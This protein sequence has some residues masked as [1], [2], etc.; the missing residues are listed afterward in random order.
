MRVGSL[1]TRTVV[2]RFVMRTA[3][4]VGLFLVWEGISAL[5]SSIYVPSIVGNIEEFLNALVS[6]GTYVS[7]GESLRVVSIGY[8]SAVGLALPAAFLCV[9][10]KT[11]TALLFPAHEF[12]RYI[13]VPALVPLAV[14]ILGIGDMSKSFLIFVGTYFHLIF[15]YCSDLSK[16]PVDALETA[17]TLGLSRFA[18]NYRIRLLESLPRIWDSSRISFGWAWSYLLIAEIINPNQGVGFKIVQSIRFEQ[19]RI[20]VWIL[21][22]GTMGLLID[23]AF[24]I[25]HKRLFRWVYIA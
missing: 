24:K 10:S 13:P 5:A 8:V 4:I 22:V 1:R 3:S 23:L 11:L 25:L 2:I 6:S 17:Y 21:L 15:L 14:V 20:M 7:L 18:G 9:Q 12:I 16:T 19:S